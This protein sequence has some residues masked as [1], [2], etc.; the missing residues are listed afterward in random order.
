MTKDEKRVLKKIGETHKAF[1]ELEQQHPDD[2]RDFING[3]HIMQGL[4]MQRVCRRSE[5]YEFPIYE[6]KVTKRVII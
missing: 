5:P 2:L 3:V 1:M 4:I 6:T